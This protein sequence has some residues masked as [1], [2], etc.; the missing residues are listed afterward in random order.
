VIR[1]ETSETG[2]LFTI[3]TNADIERT[4][5]DQVQHMVDIESVIGAL[6]HFLAGFGTAA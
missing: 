5:V 1:I 6:R 4:A 2:L 3:R